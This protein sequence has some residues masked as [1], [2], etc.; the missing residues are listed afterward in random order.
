MLRHYGLRDRPL[1]GA[2]RHAYSSA[3][4][5]CGGACVGLVGW[6]GAQF[7][8]PGMTHPVMGL[9]QLAAT[10]VSLC[11]L[12]M[13]TVSG[14]LK[15]WND[16]SVS[17]ATA[18]AI[19]VPSIFT[20]RIGARLAARLPDDVLQLTFNSA[21]VILI[22]TH[23]LVQRNAARRWGANDITVDT[24]TS[25]PGAPTTLRSDAGAADVDQQQLGSHILE[26]ERTQPQPEGMNAALAVGHCAFGCVSGVVSAVIGIG[27]L[28]L[29]MSYLTAVAEMPHHLVQGTT[30]LAVAPS[31]ITS[32]LSR[33]H[34]I[35]AGSAVAV[36]LGAMGGATV[37]AS[38]AL[39]TSEERL[40][41]LYM[42]S[43]VVLGGRS[44]VAAG[45]NLRTI[46]SR[47]HK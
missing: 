18:V 22:P 8:I 45:R 31:A 44:V 17:V 36:T 43:L 47:N 1:R 29:T 38:L 30:Q 10:G 16:S 34:V 9:S 21:S 37:G 42:L 46:W 12:S 19:A 6:G 13:S 26:C 35:P 41:E 3:V 24:A 14:A 27:G 23:L 25:R 39:R 2:W 5:F 32:A 15:F 33:V 20:A 4:G 40:R 7:I 28:P 11:S